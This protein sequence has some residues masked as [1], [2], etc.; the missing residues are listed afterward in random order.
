MLPFDVFKVAK[1]ALSL[2]RLHRYSTHSV[3]KMVA[4]SVLLLGTTISLGVGSKE[5]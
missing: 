1:D 4:V 2:K 3:E 5:V